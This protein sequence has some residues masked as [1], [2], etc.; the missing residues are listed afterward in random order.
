MRNL[1]TSLVCGGSLLLA[2]SVSAANAQQLP[3][4]GHFSI[5]Y[6]LTNPTPV[7][8]IS[9]SKDAEVT[10]SS[11]LMS[12][13]NDAGSGLLHNMTGRCLSENIVDKAAKTIE[14]HGYCT[15]VDNNGDQVFEKTD[16]KQPMAPTL[17]IQ[18]QWIGGTGKY[19]GLE[20]TFEIH[21]TP[22]KPLTE[23]VVQGIGKKVGNY[24]IKTM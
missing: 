6:T 9:I 18:G 5:T 21:H 12:A 23:G 3:A 11:S 16:Y 2:F 19:S 15:Y 10:V 8:P 1:N 24:K 4:E 22:L 20:G 13:V 7:K 14:G 17:T